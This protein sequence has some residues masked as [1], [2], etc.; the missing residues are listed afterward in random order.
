M[1]TLPE[2][3]PLAWAL[4]GEQSGGG[5]ALAA[6]VREWFADPD[7][8]RLIERLDERYY[9]FDPG[10]ITRSHAAEFRRALANTLPR[11]EDLFRREAERADVPWTLLAAVA[12]QESH[13]DPRARSPTG[14]RGLLMLTRATASD[15]GVTNRLDA[16]QSTRGGARYLASLYERVPDDIG[17]EDRWW[18]VLAAYNLGLGHVLDARQLARDQ[19]L[20]PTLWRDVR[21]VLPLLEDPAFHRDLPRGYARGREAQLYVQRVRDYLDVLE[22][23]YAGPI[24]VTPP[25]SLRAD[26]VEDPT[27]VAPESEAAATPPT[28]GE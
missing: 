23:R 20:D 28:D 18:F 3:Q 6:A 26:G 17:E 25:A 7:T 1:A 5:R 15:L 19:G 14:V 11:Y 13:W 22:K 4:G 27:P 2:E 21:T 8:Q 12:Y 9:G 24:P 16:N 10:A